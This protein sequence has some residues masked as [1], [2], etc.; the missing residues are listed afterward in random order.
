M[1]LPMVFCANNS[2]TPLFLQDKFPGRIG[3]LLT[4][5]TYSQHLDN[6]AHLTT[7]LD[8]GRYAARAMNKKWSDKAF[9][10]MLQD[11]ANL[12][13][14]PKWVVAP[15]VMRDA[16]KTIEEWNVWEPQMREFGWSI[17]LVVRQG[18]TPRIV[19]SLKHRPDV[20]FVGGATVWKR[21]SVREWCSNFPRV[22]V[23][24]IRTIKGLWTVHDAGAESS[25]SNIWRPI[26]G[27][28]KT[29]VKY[30]TESEQREERA[31]P[32]GLIPTG[33]KQQTTQPKADV[34]KSLAEKVKVKD[35]EITKR[36]AIYNGDCIQVMKGLP[37]DS[38]GLCIHSPPFADLYSYSDSHED[39]ANS[40]DYKTFFEHYRFVADELLRIMMPGRIVAVHCMDLPTHK[41]NGEEIGLKNFS[42]DI[43]NMFSS[44]GF[45][46]HSRCC[47]WKNPLVAATR[48]KALG[49]AHKQIIKDSS[50][51]R[52]G[53]AD[54]IMAFRKPGVNPEPVA[55]P[56]GLTDYAGSRPVPT[57]LDSFIGF[58]GNQK[59]NKRSHWIW[60]QYA[61]P[62]W[63]DINQTKVLPY[64]GA[65]DAD[66]EKH[67]CPLQ[68]QVIERCLIL[69]SN[70]GD[71]VFTPFMGVGSEVYMAVKL[72][73]KGVGAELKNRYFRQAVRNLHSLRK[74]K[75]DV[76]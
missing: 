39:L 50:L 4:P 55:H 67:I 48:T 33:K 57:N 61:S 71:V 9:I 32:I 22:H 29:L 44:V 40:G 10:K 31:K 54:Y 27:H 28:L 3:V 66:D 18:I 37:N 72:G 76:Q 26:G 73:R 53:I 2:E 64:R 70:L 12:D 43:E 74:S 16:E 13:I 52:T 23:G 21:R 51:C 8:N 7:V 30:L 6:A 59:G 60:Q 25:D 14:T 58:E 49:L 69:W 75:G 46:F 19:K 1:T 62:V 63:F 47:I 41:R 15:D 35:Q 36:Y 17:A 24:G 34:M 45:I 42:D 65:K 38:I 68:L 56:V 11:I 5:D 20:I